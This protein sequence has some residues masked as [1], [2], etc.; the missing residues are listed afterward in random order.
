MFGHWQAAFSTSGPQQQIRFLE[1]SSV[2]LINL[3]NKRLFW[4]YNKKYKCIYTY[5][6]KTTG[7]ET[8]IQQSVK[9][10]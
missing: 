8:V 7:L 5:I 2:L 10:M 6:Y 1:M 9:N 4:L 3:D